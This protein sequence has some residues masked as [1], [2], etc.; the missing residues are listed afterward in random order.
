MLGAELRREES[1]RAERRGRSNGGSPIE[2]DEYTDPDLDQVQG[3]NSHIVNAP[4]SPPTWHFV[5]RI[6]YLGNA[7]G[8]LPYTWM[9]KTCILHM[10]ISMSALENDGFV[11]CGAG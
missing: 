3:S 11:A 5:F 6:F 9:K 4:S 2:D 8:N 1:S 7:L 10:G